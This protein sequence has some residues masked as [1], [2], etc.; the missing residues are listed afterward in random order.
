MNIDFSIYN[1]NQLLDLQEKLNNEIENRKEKKL[2]RDIK[3]YIR[4]GEV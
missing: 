2:C 1:D 4:S 3:K